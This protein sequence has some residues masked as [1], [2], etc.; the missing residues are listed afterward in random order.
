MNATIFGALSPINPHFLTQRYLDP[1]CLRSALQSFHHSHQNLDPFPLWPD[2]SHPLIPNH[3][4]VRRCLCCMLQLCGYHG[5]DSSMPARKGNMGSHPEASSMRQYPTEFHRIVR[6]QYHHRFP[7]VGPAN[8]S[9]LA[10]G[11]VQVSKSAD[12]GFKI[13]RAHV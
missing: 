4:S 6:N 7:N 8:A 3:T 11:D 1:P 13:G 9:A 2:I 5:F 12:I 10:I